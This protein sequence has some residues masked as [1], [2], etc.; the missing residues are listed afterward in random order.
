MQP[1]GVLMPFPVEVS[2]LLVYFRFRKGTQ[3]TLSGASKHLLL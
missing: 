3:S 1:N 2:R